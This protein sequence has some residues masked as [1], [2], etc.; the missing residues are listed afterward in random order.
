MQ[1]Q[2]SGQLSANF[3]ILYSLW[4]NPYKNHTLSGTYLMLKTLPLVA[5]CFK[6]LHSV[7]LKS[8]KKGSK[9]S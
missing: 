6:T 1:L 7:A 9:P 5:H 2:K 4:H 8:V 3:D